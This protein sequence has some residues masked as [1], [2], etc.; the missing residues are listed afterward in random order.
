MHAAR[1]RPRRVPARRVIRARNRGAA[2]PA[3]SVLHGGKEVAEGL[4]QDMQSGR[5]GGSAAAAEKGASQT[6]EDAKAEGKVEGKAGGDDASRRGLVKVVLERGGQAKRH[7]TSALLVHCWYY[8]EPI[9]FITP[10]ASTAPE[11]CCCI[12]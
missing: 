10:Q 6:P 12:V 2:K 4:L 7:A 3:L 11:A 9:F 8:E 1:P 5:R